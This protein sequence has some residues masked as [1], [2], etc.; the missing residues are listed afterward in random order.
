M[1]P[2]WVRGGDTGDGSARK[3]NRAV[4]DLRKQGITEP[5]EDQ[6]KTLYI[7][8]GGAVVEVE[9]TEEAPKPKGRPKKE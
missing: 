6:I 5:T 4:E 9:P 7:K 2:A 3:Y 8:Y 1:I